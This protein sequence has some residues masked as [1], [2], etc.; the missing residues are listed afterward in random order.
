ME[1][2]KEINEDELSFPKSNPFGVPENYF[3]EFPTRISEL[4]EK[5][6]SSNI[7]SISAIRKASIFL[8]YAAIVVVVCML[9][10]KILLP[11]NPELTAEDI[12]EYMNQQGI[13]DE[14]AI[15]E[16][17]NYSSSNNSIE[18]FNI[19]SSINME[20]VNTIEAIL[21]EEDIDLNELINTL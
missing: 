17:I 21:L 19:Q 8:A 7:I 2:Q 4:I 5:G 12:S 10:F 15:D 13:T 16:I 6:D 18:T 3:N 20:E 11:N 1:N 9:G 14:L